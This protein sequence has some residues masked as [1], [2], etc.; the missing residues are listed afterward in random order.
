MNS[1]KVVASAARSSAWCRRRRKE[2]RSKP[3]VWTRRT[4]RTLDQPSHGSLTP[5]LCFIISEARGREENLPTQH[6]R[7]G[8]PVAQSAVSRRVSRRAGQIYTYHSNPSKFL[9]QSSREKTSLHMLRRC[10]HLCR[11]E[12]LPGP[13][14]PFEIY[15]LRYSTEASV[16]ESRRSSSGSSSI[17]LSRHLVRGTFR[18]FLSAK[19]R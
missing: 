8:I 19:T 9:P 13:T 7:H 12:A 5:N 6:P 15:Q 17:V 10:Y 16:V 11:D 14:D 2:E 3:F 1:F 18:G 4:R